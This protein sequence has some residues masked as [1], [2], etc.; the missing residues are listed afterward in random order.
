MSKKLLATLIAATFTCGLAS[1]QT[2]NNSTTGVVVDQPGAAA[3]NPP[4]QA[5]KDAQ[6]QSKAEYKASKKVADANKDLSK[7]EC[8]VTAD[9]SVERACKNEAKAAAKH[10]KA[11]AK[12]T[13]ET[14]K[15]Q[16]KD[17]DK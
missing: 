2:T 12:T 5:A 3:P 6:T 11:A 15:K 9:G 1:A 17:A 4:S 8:E 10:E 16:I 14:E 7:A 13:Y